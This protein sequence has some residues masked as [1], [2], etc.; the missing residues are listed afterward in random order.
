MIIRTLNSIS[1]SAFL[2]NAKWKTECNNLSHHVRRN[3]G[4][5]LKHRNFDVNNTSRVTSGRDV[6]EDSL[7]WLKIIHHYGN[8][9]VSTEFCNG[10]TLNILKEKINKIFFGFKILQTH[11]E[12]PQHCVHSSHIRPLNLTL[13]CYQN[14]TYIEHCPPSRVC[15]KHTTSRKLVQQVKTEAYS[16][17]AH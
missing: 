12:C 2:Q 13:L 11:T 6:T 10:E 7:I 9:A 8:S 4:W 1:I 15:C 16:V 5:R 14:D 3:T 17:W